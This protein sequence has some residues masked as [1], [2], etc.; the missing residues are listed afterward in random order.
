M[1]S[2][3]D[4]RV[5][6]PSEEWQAVC[7]ASVSSCFL[8]FDQSSHSSSNSKPMHLSGIPRLTWVLKNQHQLR[9][10][11]AQKCLCWTPVSALGQAGAETRALPVSQSFLLDFF[12]SGK[13]IIYGSFW[14]FSFLTVAG[15]KMLAGLH[16]LPG[17]IFVSSFTKEFGD[18]TLVFAT[19]T[20][21]SKHGKDFGCASV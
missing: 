3:Q 17:A 1:E 15:F 4:S 13:S 6:R 2:L 10:Q 20:S 16:T 8:A 12:L 9:E 18:L 11:N 19:L 7:F 21:T 5:W 14:S